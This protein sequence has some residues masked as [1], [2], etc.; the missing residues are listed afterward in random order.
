MKRIALFYNPEK[1]LAVQLWRKTKGW[2]KQ[3][4]ITAVTPGASHRALNDIDCAIALGGDGTMLKVARVIAPRGIPL[5]G[6]NLGSLG[7]LAEIDW[8]ETSATLSQIIKGNYHIENRAMLSVKTGTSNA[9]RQIALN[10][11]VIRCGG[12]ARV[13]VLDVWVGSQHLARYLGDGLIVATP[14]GSTAYSLAANGPIVH[15]R[16]EVFIIT[17]IC[18]HTLAQ[19]PIIISSHETIRITVQRHDLHDPVIVSVDGQSTTKVRTGGSVLIQ[20]AEQDLRLITK[21]NQDFFSILRE[22][23]RWG[24]R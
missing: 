13:I 2:L 20:R 6:V 10:D 5:L 4:G 9:Y 12:N 24:E 3:H 19:R 17:P 7:F 21:T 23:L 8:H 1:P 18:S 15:P 11:C 22:K 14:T 16:L